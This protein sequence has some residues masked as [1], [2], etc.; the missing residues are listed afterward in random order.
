MNEKMSKII[1]WALYALLIISAIIGI[2]FYTDAVGQTNLLLY[3]GYFL[4]ILVIATTLIVSLMGI[5]QNPKS[6]IKMLIILVGMI[7]VFF[8]A[9]TMSK[10]NFSPAF[11]EKHEVSA[12]TVRVVGA[13]LLVTYL[14]GIGAIVAIVY[15]AI[16]RMF[17]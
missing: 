3:W 15:S 10:N 17:K 7:V 11:L 5:L 4:L 14:F 16:S 13:G 9:Y 8:L 12:S 6:S 2:V 1:Q